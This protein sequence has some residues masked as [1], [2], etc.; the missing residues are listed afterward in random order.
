MMLGEDSTAG[1]YWE[2][3]GN[4][5]GIPVLLID[6]ARNVDETEHESLVARGVAP[7]PLDTEGNRS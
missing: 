4:P 1:R 7:A 3:V 6:E 5:D 2:E